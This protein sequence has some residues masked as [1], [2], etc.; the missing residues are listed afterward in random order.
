MPKKSIKKHLDTILG[1]ID[2][3][4]DFS[5]KK[6]GEAFRIDVEGDDLNFLIGYRGESL[7]AL[8]YILSHAVFK[9]KE[10]WIPITLDINGYRQ[11]KLDKLEEMVR[12]F[13]DRARFHQKEIRLPVLTPYERRHVH[14][15]IADYI[16]VESESRGDGRDR[17][18]FVIP[19]KSD[20]SDQEDNQE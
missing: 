8:Q 7:D 6:D 15:L 1:F 14:M 2:I 19:G 17:R 5:V 10:E 16:D 20:Q 11:G 18:L 3:S 13:V 9:E 12:G 4:P